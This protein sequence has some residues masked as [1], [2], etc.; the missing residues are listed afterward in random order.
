MLSTV[1][2]RKLEAAKKGKGVLCRD[3]VPADAARRGRQLRSSAWRFAST[4]LQG[5]YEPRTE[6][7]ADRQ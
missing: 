7:A 1:N 5:A 2:R 4:V 3:R 6:A